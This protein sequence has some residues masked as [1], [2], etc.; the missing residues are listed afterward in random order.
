MVYMYLSVICI[1][2]LL[3]SPSDIIGIKEVTLILEIS[4]QCDIKHIMLLPIKTIVL[5][6]SF[7]GLNKHYH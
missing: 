2:F 3:I 1:F 4:S 5:K 6:K 7:E